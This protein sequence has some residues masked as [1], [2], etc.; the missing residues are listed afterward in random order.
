MT[1]ET[2]GGVKMEIDRLSDQINVKWWNQEVE[3]FPNKTVYHTYEWLEFIERSQGL[4][5]IIY[6][7]RIDGTVVC[8]LPGFAIRKGPLKIFASPFPGW[9]TPYMGPLLLESVPQRLF[10]D[11]FRRLMNKEGYHYAELC[12]R[13]LNHELAKEEGFAVEEGVT[14]VAEI[15]ANADEILANFKKS[16]RN[17]TRKGLGNCDLVVETT[18]DSS[19]V[20][21]FYTQLEQVFAKS[22]MKPTYPKERVKILIETMLPTDRL[23]LTWVKH[24]HEPI[25]CQISLIYGQWMHAFASASARDYLRLRPNELLRFHTMRTASERGVRYYDMTGGGS[26]KANFGGKETPVHRI[27]YGTPGLHKAR[28]FAKSVTRL[29]NRIKYAFHHHGK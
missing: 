17:A 13:A 23:L 21:H 19:S 12:N 8:Y 6:E 14:Y 18:T 1:S 20:D 26:Y 15:G 11:E 28:N 29:K 7:I 27:I 9:T 16:T 3:R 4:R 24:K 10:F 5:K 25:A 2:N 22:R